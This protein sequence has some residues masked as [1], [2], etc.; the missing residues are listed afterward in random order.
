[1]RGRLTSTLGRRTGGFSPSL[2]SIDRALV[3]RIWSPA[4]S[5]LRRAL[6]VGEHAR[7]PPGGGA[8]KLPLHP[9][10]NR[11]GPK[12]ADSRFCSR[13]NDVRERWPVG[14]VRARPVQNHPQRTR[15]I[16]QQHP[17]RL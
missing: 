9:P 15:P 12:L 4:I 1:M 2:T 11:R 5:F 6:L 14:S 3:S 13:E 7:S 10:E 17:I 8:E 16:L